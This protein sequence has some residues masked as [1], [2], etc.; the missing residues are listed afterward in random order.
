ML[1]K[2]EGH[3]LATTHPHDVAKFY[4]YLLAQLGKLYITHTQLAQAYK[5][6]TSY[7]KSGTIS[8]LPLFTLMTY[9]FTEI[10]LLC[11]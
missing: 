6:T 8:I 5:G 7:Y 9:L 4:G 3:L 1:A 10:L 11:T 2:S